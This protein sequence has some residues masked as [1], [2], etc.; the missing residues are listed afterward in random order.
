MTTETEKITADN[1]WNTDLEKIEK[2]FLGEHKTVTDLS[3]FPKDHYAVPAEF[4]ESILN[5]SNDKIDTITFDIP[6]LIRLLEYSREELKSDD[7]LHSL[8]DKIISASKKEKLINMKILTKIL[9][10][11]NN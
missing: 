8:S 10:K 3:F 9:N 1:F 11:G 5:V 2:V 4:L 7:S 6:A